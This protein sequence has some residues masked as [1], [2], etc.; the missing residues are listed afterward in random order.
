MPTKTMKT[1]SPED[2]HEEGEE[3]EDGNMEEIE[4]ENEDDEGSD[5]GDNDEEEEM[6]LD[7]NLYELFKSNR[8]LN[9]KRFLSS[10]HEK[11]VIAMYEN[12]SSVKT[13]R[14]ILHVPRLEIINGYC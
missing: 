3:D 13:A 7:E 6:L 1:Q 11:A 10:Y 5:V 2:N 14:S 9:L 4:E 12:D 8:G